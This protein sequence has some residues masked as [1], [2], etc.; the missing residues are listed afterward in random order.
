MLF[1]YFELAGV[2]LLMSC[3]SSSKVAEDFCVFYL[4]VLIGILL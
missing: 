3:V 4:I 1:Y 2:F